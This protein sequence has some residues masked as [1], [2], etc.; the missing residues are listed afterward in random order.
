MLPNQLYT[1]RKYSLKNE[2]ET[3]LLASVAFSGFLVLSRILVTGKFT[4]LFLC[5]N[6]FLAI[7]PYVISRYTWLYLNRI[8]NRFLLGL[9]F[10]AW[11][12][13]IPNSFYIITDLFHLGNFSHAPLWFDL[14]VIFSF[15]WNGLILGILSV[16]QMEK[17]F[18]TTFGTSHELL[19]LYPVMWLNALGVYI[20][21][22][23]RFNSWDIVTSPF[24]LIIDVIDLLI[25]PAENKGAI[26]MVMTYSI[27][28]TIIYLSIRRMSRHV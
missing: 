28:M 12:L 5:W 3:L 1:L 27:F 15:A 22:F 6:L 17:V 9:I 18:H 16:R 20:G 19:F 11:L 25:H 4:F 10:F 21:R 23:L 26:G 2:T 7:V 13:F 14:L 24:Q 8:T